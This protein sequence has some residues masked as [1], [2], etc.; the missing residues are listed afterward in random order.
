[1]SSLGGTS[2]RWRRIIT[3]EL[4]SS[5]RVANL[6]FLVLVVAE[7][8]FH[9]CDSVLFSPSSAPPRYAPGFPSCET[10]VEGTAP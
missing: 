2:A 3:L 1:M 10:P 8:V 5:I 6:Y 9:L 7:G 4:T